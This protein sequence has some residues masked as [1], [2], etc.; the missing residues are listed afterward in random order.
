MF[1]TICF[2]GIITTDILE[3]DIATKLPLTTQNRSLEPSER[4]LYLQQYL[5]EGEKQK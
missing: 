5:F 4:H 1:M 2:I 3:P